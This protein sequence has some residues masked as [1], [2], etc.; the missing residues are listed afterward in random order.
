VELA[1]MDLS[2]LARRVVEGVQ[3]TL[4][5]HTVVFEGDDAPI[6]VHGDASRLEQVLQNLVQNAVKYSPHGGQVTLRVRAAE[7]A[8][9]TVED[10]G[11]GIPRDALP[12]LFQRFYRVEHATTRGI[13]GLGI[14][15]YVVQEIVSLH[16]GTVAVES[17]VGRGSRFFVRL[18]RIDVEAG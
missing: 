13:S 8:E 6:L 16:G 2:A 9:V 12:R 4:E 18:P 1:P 5:R 10:R 3:P 17:E 14:G 11:V 7:Q 15:L